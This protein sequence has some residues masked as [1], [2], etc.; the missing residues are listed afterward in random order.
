MSERK[1]VM[2]IPYGGKTEHMVAS[3][4]FW[5]KFEWCSTI[6]CFTSTRD[7]YFTSTIQVNWF[8]TY[9]TFISCFPLQ[10]FDIQ[11]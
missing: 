11:A 2:I 5:G 7:I 6:Q 4:I 3:G 10:Q 9:D 8:G 1:D